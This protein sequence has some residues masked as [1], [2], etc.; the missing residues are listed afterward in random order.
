MKKFA[1]AVLESMKYAFCLYSSDVRN[2]MRY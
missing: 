2:V 1:K